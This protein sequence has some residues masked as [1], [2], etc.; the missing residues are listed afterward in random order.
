MANRFLAVNGLI[1]PSHPQSKCG[2]SVGLLWLETVS[3]ARLLVIFTPAGFEGFYQDI[4]NEKL[5]SHGNRAGREPDGRLAASLPGID[6]MWPTMPVAG[7]TPIRA[8][9]IRNPIS[10]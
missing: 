2:G 5:S 10:I 4:A 6:M 9:G 3:L 7:T 1:I 8:C